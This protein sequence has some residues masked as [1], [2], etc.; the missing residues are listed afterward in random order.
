MREFE[1]IWSKR[2]IYYVTFD[3]LIVEKIIDWN[4]E[5]EP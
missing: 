2:G 1:K 3:N 5:F 4:G